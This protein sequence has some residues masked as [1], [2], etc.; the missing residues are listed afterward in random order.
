V[1]GCVIADN[2]A[3]GLGSEAGGGGVYNDDFSSPSMVNCTISGNTA[4]GKGGG[5]R[6]RRSSP[7]L[8]NC[9]FGNNIASDEGGGVYTLN[10]GSA[11]SPH[12]ANCILSGDSP[13]ELVD[14]GPVADTTVMHSSI[15][16]G[17]SGAG[18]GNIDADPLF[19]DPDNG[20]LR[21][22]PGSPCIDAADNTAVPEGITTDLDGN[23]RFVDD[24]D[25]LDS[26]YGDPPIVDMGAYEFQGAS[27]PWDLDDDGTVSVVDLLDVIASW[28]PCEACPADFNNDG[29]VNVVDLLGLIANFGPCPGVPCVWDVTGDGVVDQSDLQQVQENFGPCDGCAEDVNGDGMVNGQDAAA[30]ATHFGPCP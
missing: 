6:N 5:M 23:P 14:D 19:V 21:L 22:Q 25:I 29:L 8:I 2:S 28:G 30:V 9:T 7:L 12:L 27:C 10:W 24:P 26:G 4:A 1:I 11:G 17:W 3:A 18:S 13:D 20:D 16:G 15:S